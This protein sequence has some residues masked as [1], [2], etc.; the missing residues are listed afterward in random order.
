MARAH[1]D[2][3]RDALHETVATKADL[4]RATAKLE[5]DIAELR[6][7]VAREIG[8]PIGIPGERDDLCVNARSEVEQKRNGQTCA[9]GRRNAAEWRRRDSAPAGVVPAIVLN[10]VHRSLLCT[11]AG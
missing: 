2:V 4:D 9:S 10:V 1:A 3:L 11:I 7:D 5:R 8:L 6:D